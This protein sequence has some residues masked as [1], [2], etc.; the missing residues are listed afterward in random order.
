[1]PALLLIT[2]LLVCLGAAAAHAAGPVGASYPGRRLSRMP[3]PA[4]L[5][6]LTSP[7]GQT[8]LFE[9]EYRSD[10]LALLASYVAQVNGAFCG[11]AS[12][13]TVLNALAV[14]QPLQASG[15]YLDEPE[16]AYYTQDNVFDADSERVVPRSS[17]LR[18][19]MSLAELA[20]F[21]AAHRGVNASFKHG[22]DMS[23]QDF[24]DAV[25]SAIAQP[26]TFAIV[27]F[28]RSAIGEVGGGHHSPVGAY[29]ATA[30]S[31]LVLDVARY[32]YP[33]FWVSVN[34]LYHATLPSVSDGQDRGLVF[35]WAPE[36]EQLRVGPQYIMAG[37]D[38]G[39]PMSTG[40]NHGSSSSDG[41]SG[42]PN[43]QMATA[44]VASFMVGLG[45]ALTA[46]ALLSASG[47]VT[48]SYSG[49]ARQAK[50]EEMAT[51]VQR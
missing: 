34:A 13:V 45:V 6:P 30:D 40:P 11:P 2:S 51:L 5:T 28:L 22:S 19:G 23:L 1:M 15:T 25:V 41:S 16:Y 18:N 46:A 43:W 20:S 9:A 47:F 35:V 39:H 36:G 44:A 14:G 27:N 42:F 3:L 24:R 32:K 49:F 7:A 33:A 48:I 12:S 4:E 21:L 17:V 29:H 38:D 50:H 26:Q 31:L 8:M 37:V 10:A